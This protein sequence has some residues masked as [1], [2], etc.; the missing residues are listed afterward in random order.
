MVRLKME[1]GKA[2]L[3]SKLSYF[4]S[5]LDAINQPCIEARLNADAGSSDIDSYLSFMEKLRFV[6]ALGRTYYN[7]QARA[8]ESGVFDI[9]SLLH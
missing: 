2:T 1:H 4:R 5:I 6:L 9:K 7:W 8:R 3:L